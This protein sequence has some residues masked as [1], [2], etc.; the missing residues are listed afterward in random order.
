MILEP[1]PLVFWSG[2]FPLCQCI[3]Y[4]FPLYVYYTC[5]IWFY[6]EFLDQFVLQLFTGDKNGSV[7]IPL[8]AEHHLNQHHLLKML[9]FFH[10]MFWFLCQILSDHKCVN[11]FL[12]FQFY[13]IYL[14]TCLCTNTMQFLSFFFS[15]VHTAWG[16]DWWF[17]KKLFFCWEWFLISWVFLLFQINLRI[18]LSISVK[19]WVGIS[20]RIVLNA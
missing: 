20:N 6:V 19:N 9:S 10:W 3:Q 12:A 15:L 16:Q 7:C 2:K 1:E 13:S 14:P 17:L 18:A 5:H 4:S 11:L 8:Y